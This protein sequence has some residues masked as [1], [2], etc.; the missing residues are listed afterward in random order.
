[1]IAEIEAAN[2]A[3]A[4]GGRM[5]FPFERMFPLGDPP[6]YEPAADQ[7]VAAMAARAG[8]SAAAMAFDLLMADDGRAV[9]YVPF[10]NY[11]DGNLDAVREMLLHP[12]PVVGLGRRRCPRGHHLRRQLP[13]HDAHALGA[14]PRRRPRIELETVVAKQTSRTAAMVGLGDRGVLAPGMRADVNVIDLDQ[15]D[16]APARA[17]VRPARRRQAVP[18]AGRRLPATRSSPASRPT[19]RAS[20]PARCPAASS[21]ARDPAPIA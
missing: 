3:A 11:S 10:L 17:G 5:R 12:Q 14:R 16:A 8:V 7:S 1:M 4:E 2:A 21:A 18:A 6:N 9:L 20:T 19:P 13:H 15:P